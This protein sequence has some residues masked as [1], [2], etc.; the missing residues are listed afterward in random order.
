[1]F[2]KK[3]MGLFSNLFVLELTSQNLVAGA[4]VGNNFTLGGLQENF[5]VL[6]K[7]I[8]RSN[9]CVKRKVVLSVSMR[10]GV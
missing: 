9:S 6:L 10:V 4:L 2:V 3:L 8:I 5:V 1:M 7:I